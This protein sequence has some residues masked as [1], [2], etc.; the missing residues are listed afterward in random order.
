MHDNLRST[1]TIPASGR[2]PGTFAWISGAVLIL[3]GGLFLLHNAG[4]IATLGHWWA[5]FLLIPVAITAGAAWTQYRAGS[6]RL[7]PAA[8]GSLIASLVLATVAA[9]FLLNLS[10]GTV[11][12]VFL[13]I[14]GIATLLQ[15]AGWRGGD[16]GVRGVPG[17]RM[18]DIGR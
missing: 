6:R 13:I 9:I 4:V 10:W 16:R 1:T 18:Q 17:R 12:P 8:S 5:L 15:W 11:W 2:T 3:L 7:T 14:A